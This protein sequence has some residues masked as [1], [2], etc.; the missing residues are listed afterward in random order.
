MKEI[1]IDGIEYLLTPKV[2]EEEF[3]YPMWFKRK[4]GAI[5]RFDALNVAV[6]K[7]R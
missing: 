4:T 1:T 2:K 7:G 3:T 6:C 5:C